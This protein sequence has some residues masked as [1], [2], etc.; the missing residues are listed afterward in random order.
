MILLSGFLLSLL[1]TIALIPIVNR[2]AVK[3]HAIDVPDERKVHDH[4]IPRSGGIAM[5][6]GVILPVL[7]LVPKNPSL[8]SYVIGSLIIVIF[9]FFDD[10]RGMGYK[11]KFAIQIAAALIVVVFGGITITHLGSFLPSGWTLPDFIAIPFTVLVIVGITNAINLADGLDGLAGGIS[12][13]GFCCIAYLAHLEH[14]NT[15]VIVSL[16]LAG[17][18]FGFLRFNTF[19]AT[20]FMG[21]AGSQFLGFS[22]IVLSLMITQESRSLSPFLPVLIVGFPVLDTTL[23]MIKRITEG[24]HIFSPDKKHFH[25]RLI[26]LG[27]Y[28]TEAVTVIYFIQALFVVTAIFLKYYSDWLLLIGYSAF[29]ICIASLL[30]I[31]NRNKWTFTRAGFFDAVVKDRLRRLR[32]KRYAIR[33]SFQTIEYGLPLVLLVTSFLPSSIPVYLSFASG[34]AIICLLALR[35]FKRSWELYALMVVLYLFTPFLVFL[36]TEQWPEWMNVPYKRVYELSFLV[37]AFFM[38]ATLKFTHRQQGFTIKPTDFLILFIALVVP[39]ILADVMNSKNLAAIATKTIVFFFGY[40][41]LVGEMR[42]EYGKLIWFT[43]IILAVVLVRGFF[44]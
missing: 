43:I 38:I 22:A 8:V 18:I 11:S 27:L 16:C 21:D 40:E 19:P 4:P 30:I 13:L 29:S 6:L 7:L 31:A 10:F 1:I 44:A 34:T 2:I 39:Y 3:I 5:A 41:I 12:L 35:R 24:R 17:S 42:G 37:L 15:I 32:G 26:H 9:G 23:V 28:H 33:V 14:H 36:S 20:I 25:H